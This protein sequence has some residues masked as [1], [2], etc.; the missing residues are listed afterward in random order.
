MSYITSFSIDFSRIIY[1]VKKNLLKHSDTDIYFTIGNVVYTNNHISDET[2]YLFAVFMIIEFFINTNMN[3]ENDKGIKKFFN[4]KRNFGLKVID[5][6]N[7]KFKEIKHITH[8]LS[9]FKIYFDVFWTKDKLYSYLQYLINKI[10]NNDLKERL[11][12]SLNY[13]ISYYDIFFQKLNNI[14]IQMIEFNGINVDLNNI[15]YDFDNYD[16]ELKE[17]QEVAL[18]MVSL[19]QDK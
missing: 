4:H 9:Q 5:L 8:S 15:T 13:I 12:Y 18:I 3:N 2:N 10:Q 14:I 17:K 11:Y 7:N 6:L 19:V 16:E 1:C